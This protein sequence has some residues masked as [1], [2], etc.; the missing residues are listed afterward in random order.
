[1]LRVGASQPRVHTRL[2]SLA[3]GHRRNDIYST[4]LKVAEVPANPNFALVS[5][6]SAMANEQAVGVLEWAEVPR[7]ELHESEYQ[8]A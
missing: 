1:M 4:M 8:D 5:V 6:A 2:C 7:V 3:G